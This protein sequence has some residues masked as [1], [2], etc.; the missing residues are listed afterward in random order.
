MEFKAPASGLPL[1]VRHDQPSWTVDEGDTANPTV[2]FTWAPG[3]AAPRDSFTIFLL[4]EGGGGGR[5]L[6]MTTSSSRKEEAIRR[7][8]LCLRAG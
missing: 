5:N 7:R 8:Q 1:S 2:T 6:L 4:T 3:L